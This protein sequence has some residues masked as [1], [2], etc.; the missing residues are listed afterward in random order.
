MLRRDQIQAIF[1]QMAG[2]N[3]EEWQAFAQHLEEVTFPKHDYLCR[4]GETAQYLYFIY[5]GAVRVYH[6]TEEQEF[7]LNF[8]F[9]NEFVTAFSSFITQT[10]SRVS[11][12]ALEQ[13]QASRIHHQHLYNTYQQY[14]HAERIGRLFAEKLYVQKTNREIDLLSLSAEQQYLNLLQKN[15][16]LISQI[17]VKHLASYLGIHPESLSRIR[18]KLAVNS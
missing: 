17:S 3:E 4:A 18:H 8:H 11:L 10:P 9:E 15:P 7:T 12:Q 5:T 14:H 2:I 16:K 13:V 1:R 6:Q